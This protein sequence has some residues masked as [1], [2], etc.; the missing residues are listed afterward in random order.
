[1]VATHPYESPRLLTYDEVAE[2]TRLP[3]GTLRYMRH[4]GYGPKS[5]KLGRQVRFDYEDV[6]DWIEEQ[7]KE[8]RSKCT[9]NENGTLPNRQASQGT[10]V[11]KTRTFS[12]KN[13]HEPISH[14]T[15]G[16]A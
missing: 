14:S 6:L 5:F 11:S 9:C 10:A 16:A 3:V 12:N 1:M 7:R 4:N 2:M 8:G 15:A 13:G